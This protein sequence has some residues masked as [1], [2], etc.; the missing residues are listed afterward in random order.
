METLVKELNDYMQSLDKDLKVLYQ[1]DD[2][3]NLLYQEMPIFVI[4]LKQESFNMYGDMISYM[5]RKETYDNQIILIDQLKHIKT[6]VDK[7]LELF[8]SQ[9]K[10]IYSSND[11]Y[12]NID[13]NGL[14]LNRIFKTRF[15]ENDSRLKNFNLS[16]FNKIK[17]NEDF[18]KMYN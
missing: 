18:G 14:D 4:D 2:K 17:S 1:Y 10:Y 8:N 3:I 12:V 7:F 13:V 16:D 5:F 11:L 9:D 15:F 6:F